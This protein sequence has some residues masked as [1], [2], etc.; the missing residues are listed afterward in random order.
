MRQRFQ[1]Q[2]GT[3]EYAIEWIINSGRLFT[4]SMT[5]KLFDI[6]EGLTCLQSIA[7]TMAN[8]KLSVFPHWIELHYT[9]LH[10]VEFNR[11]PRSDFDV[12]LQL[13]LFDGLK[14]AGAC[15]KSLLFPFP[16][17]FIPFP[18]SLSLLPNL[19]FFPFS[20]GLPFFPTWF[21]SLF[22]LL[23]FCYIFPFP[24]HNLDIRPHQLVLLSLLF[25]ISSQIEKND[26]TKK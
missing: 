12:Q 23:L 19:I 22:F 18:P 11:A 8:Q 9:G 13:D 24:F 15:H 25:T 7:T 10:W 1:I 21:S 20:F 5:V 4:F 6:A 26:E 16:F 17:V 3:L 14:A 2:F